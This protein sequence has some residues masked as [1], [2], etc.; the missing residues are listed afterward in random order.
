MINSKINLGIKIWRR[1]KS[2]FYLFSYW[3]DVTCGQIN[4]FVCKKPRNGR[5]TT[6]PPTQIP[7]GKAII[8]L[9]SIFPNDIK[10]PFHC[11]KYLK[12]FQVTVPVTGWSLRANAIRSVLATSR[13][14]NTVTAPSS[15]SEFETSM[16]WI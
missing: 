14:C 16:I 5:Y 13:T 2:E 7:P 10:D 12:F 3:N 8:A 15:L 6:E 1:K 9:H 4:A 11:S